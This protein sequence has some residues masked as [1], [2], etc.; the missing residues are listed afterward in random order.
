MTDEFSMQFECIETNNV[1][2]RDMLE[3]QEVFYD[4]LVDYT[5][6][7]G[8]L[9]PIRGDKMSKVR[10]TLRQLVRDWSQEGQ[11]ERDACYKAMLEQLSVSWSAS[12]DIN[13]KTGGRVL[14]PGSGLG[15]QVYMAAQQ[16]YHAYGTETSYYMLLP[17]Y[18]ILNKLPQE[19]YYAIYPEVMESINWM[20]MQDRRMA[21]NIPDVYPSKQDLS[22]SMNM[23]AEN[24]NF[25]L[26]TRKNSELYDAV[27]TCYFLD[28]ANNIQ[29]YID[30]IK[31]C[32]QPEGV[33]INYGPLLYHYSGNHHELSIDLPWDLVVKYATRKGFHSCMETMIENCSYTQANKNMLQTRYTCIFSVFQVISVENT[34]TS[35][36]E[37][38]KNVQFE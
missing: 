20:S 16:G 34:D 6:V 15:R 22:G 37:A 23:I 36:Q 30:I 5:R 21:I 32:L 29:H 17:A 1:F 9:G 2:I 8:L 13:P 11:Q 4:P 18:Y 12:S 25:M 33:W 26:N 27:L 3:Y 7:P 28:T 19:K 38:P 35:E 14:I 24:F 31:A 10:S